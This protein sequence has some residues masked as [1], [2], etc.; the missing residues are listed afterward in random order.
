MTKGCS[1]RFGNPDLQRRL[2]AELQ[3]R[4]LPITLGRD[5]AVECSQEEWAGINEIAHRI[6]DGCFPWYFS[7][8][9]TAEETR[10]FADALGRAGLRFELEHHWDRDVFLLPKADR[11]EHHKLKIQMWGNMDE[12]S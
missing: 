4:R 9:E 3:A 12:E 10:A 7:W 6:R 11:A 2:L 5:G 8:L 1:L